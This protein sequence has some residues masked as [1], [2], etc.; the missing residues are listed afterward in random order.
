MTYERP[1]IYQMIEPT[2]QHL[3]ETRGYF[4]KVEVVNEILNMRNVGREFAKMPTGFGFP[5]CVIHD[6][7]AEVGR[8]LQ[9]KDS[10]GLRRYECYT[11]GT[12]Y[13][14]LRTGVMNASQ[15]R[16]VAQGRRTQS[17]RMDKIAEAYEQMALKLDVMGDAATV[18]DLS[19]DE[20]RAILRA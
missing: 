10:R 4:R 18:D 20:V 19:D 2:I 8:Q 17:R 9:R 6:L 1:V 13:R 11:D 12:G 3:A 15:L 14:W 16:T 5:V 7:E